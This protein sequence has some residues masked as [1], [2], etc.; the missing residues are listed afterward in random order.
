METPITPAQALVLRDEHL[1]PFV[2]EAVNELIETKLQALGWWCTVTVEEI[3]ALA[4]VKA[5]RATYVAKSDSLTRAY[6]KS[7]WQVYYRPG[8]EIWSGGVLKE[9]YEFHIR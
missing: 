4:S 8:G 2:I 3:E 6:A 1:D 7:G 9:E 5:G